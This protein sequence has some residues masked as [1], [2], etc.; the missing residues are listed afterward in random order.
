MCVCV[1]GGGGELFCV[2]VRCVYVHGLYD[3]TEHMCMCSCVCVCVLVNLVD[4]FS[5]MYVFACMYGCLWVRVRVRMRVIY[6]CICACVC[7]VCMWVCMCVCGVHV[8]VGE[9]V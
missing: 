6:L 4:T 9:A 7:S 8:R 5:G 3:I 1:G 2:N